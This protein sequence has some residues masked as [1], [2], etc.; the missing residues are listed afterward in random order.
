MWRLQHHIPK[1][2]TYLQRFLRGLFPR[3]DDVEHV[4]GQTGPCRLLL[5]LLLRRVIRQRTAAHPL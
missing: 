5:Q 1:E 3:E 4:K 2:I